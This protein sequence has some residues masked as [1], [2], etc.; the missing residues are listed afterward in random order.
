MPEISA[1]W[2]RSK[3]KLESRD[4]V[5]GIMIEY[6]MP[7]DRQD[8]AQA[9]VKIKYRSVAGW[10]S[11][12][13]KDLHVCLCTCICHDFHKTHALIY[14]VT[15]MIS[16]KTHALIYSVTHMISMKMHALI[17][18]VTHMISMKTHALIYSV[19]QIHRKL[20][21]RAHTCIC[22]QTPKEIIYTYTYIYIYIYI[23]I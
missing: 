10:D 17:Y 15:H 13:R 18:S 23:Y 19:T 20:H 14:S 8:P 3:Y 9:V 22:I 1:V 4:K 12:N 2:E 16:M 5:E 11:R 21:A 7:Q 6:R